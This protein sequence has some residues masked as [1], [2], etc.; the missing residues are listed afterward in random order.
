MESCPG[1]EHLQREPRANVRKPW[2][3]PNECDCGHQAIA[4][5]LLPGHPDG[6]TECHE[7]EDCDCGRFRY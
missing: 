3:Q 1:Y 2:K 5:V 4:H 6:A 7:T